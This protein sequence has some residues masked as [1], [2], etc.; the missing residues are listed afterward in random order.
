MRYS[1]SEMFGQTF[2]VDTFNTNLS[3]YYINL[4]H[5]KDWVDA[6]NQSITFI[7]HLITL[8]L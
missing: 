4:K 3:Q 2:L 1:I 7:L 8:H 6:K 5:L